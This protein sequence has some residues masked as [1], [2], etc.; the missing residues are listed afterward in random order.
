MWPVPKVSCAQDTDKMA[1]KPT[2]LRR[3]DLAT[4]PL[5]APNSKTS[6]PVPPGST[7][8]ALSKSGPNAPSVKLVRHA[9][10]ALALAQ[11]ARTPLHASLA[12]TAS[13]RL[14]REHS[15][16]VSTHVLVALTQLQTR[17]LMHLG[18]QPVIPVTIALKA[19]IV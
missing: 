18:A 9:L 12:S 15:I 3:L 16:R 7:R 4:T 14:I 17:L 1:P 5:K 8:P 13:K 19:P 11:V 10:S 6:L 2:T